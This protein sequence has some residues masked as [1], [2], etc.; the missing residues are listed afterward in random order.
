MF[1][2]FNVLVLLLSKEVLASVLTS[3]LRACPTCKGKQEPAGLNST[4][5]LGE[6]CGVYTLKC[7]RGLRCEPPQEEPRPLRALLE[8]RGVCSYVSTTQTTTTT[9]VHTEGRSRPTA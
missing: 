6:P 7:A 5:L 3:P 4:L 2:S 9:Q 8:G 1:L